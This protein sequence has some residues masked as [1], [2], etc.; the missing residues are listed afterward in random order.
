MKNAALAFALFAAVAIAWLAPASL[1]PRDTVQDSGDPLHIAWILAWDAH[2]LARNPMRL[3]ESNSFFPYA[4]SLGFSE[5]LLP[6]AILVAPVNWLTGN[7]VLA[8]NLSAWLGLTLSAF[9]MWL[10]VR[11]WTGSPPAA[12][13]AALLY[14]FNT[15]TRS[16]APRLH[17]LHMQWWPLALLMLTRYARDRRP[18]HAWAFAGFLLLQGL[19]CTYY[20]V[21]SVALAPLWVAGVFWWQ[22]RAPSR[23]ERLTLAVASVAAAA[24]ALGVLWPLIA[25]IRA[26]GFEKTWSAGV[27]L[28]AYLWPQPRHL[29]WG[30]LARSS[31]SAVA[32]TPHFLGLAGVVAMA[33]GALVGLARHNSRPLAAIAAGTLLIGLAFSFGPDLL[34]GGKAVFPAPYGFLYSHIPLLR[35]MASPERFAVLVRFGGALLIGFAAAAALRQPV[36]KARR[37][38]ATLAALLLVGEHW[39]AAAA[40][41]KAPVGALVPPVYG[42]LA[43]EGKGPLIELP[44]YHERVKRLRAAYMYFSTLHWRPI[45][46]G[47]TSFYPPDHDYLAWSLRDFPDRDSV[48]ILRRLGIGTIVVHPALWREPKRGEHLRRLDADPRLQLVRTFGAADPS[49][50]PELG[51]GEERVYRVVLEA[52]AAPATLPCTPE[53][54]LPRA[55]WQLAHSG[56][57]LPR[58]AIDGDQRTAWF[59]HEPMRPGDY[60]EVRLAAPAA[61]AAIAMDAS[62]PYDEFPRNLAVETTLD[63]TTWQPWPMSRSLDESW[64]YIAALIEHPRAAQFVSRPRTVAVVRGVRLSIARSG[65]DDAWPQWRIAELRLYS[66][67]RDAA[68]AAGRV[69]GSGS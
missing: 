49:L 13:L 11:E 18:A 31:P 2:Q 69:V 57:K 30:F 65:W 59:T 50:A 55:G 52:P 12:V 58:L 45:P 39:T 28:L 47:R 60:F 32:D 21:F 41:W 27:D 9:A 17:L 23:T 66:E 15:F 63:G 44:V 26:M 68:A 48:E 40:P 25:N 24:L 10:L 5:H 6:E 36:T 43:T 42:W 19:S 38:C 7:A 20:L 46:L 14:A 64:Q 62:Y 54:E 1:S 67:C 22:R 4:R 35:G 53:N 37:V 61:V 33:Y 51:L 56:R 3:Y 34:V 16:E 8:A 29:L